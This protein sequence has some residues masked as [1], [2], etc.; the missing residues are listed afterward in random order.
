MLGFKANN[1]FEKFIVRNTLDLYSDNFGVRGIGIESE[2]PFSVDHTITLSPSFRFYH[3]E[4]SRY[5]QSYG[6]HDITENYYTSDHDLSGFNSYKIGMGFRYNPNK[7]LGRKYLFNELNLRYA[8]YQQDNELKAHIITFV[9]M[10]DKSYRKRF[11][12]E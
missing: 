10:I 2:F 11:I 5:F 7:K 9:F 6:M 1:Y 8:L 4:S 12:I 3:Q